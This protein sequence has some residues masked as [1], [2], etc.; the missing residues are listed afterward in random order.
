[1][2]GTEPG[3]PPRERPSHDALVSRLLCSFDLHITQKQEI[4]FF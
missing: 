3:P 1:M 2:R 4:T